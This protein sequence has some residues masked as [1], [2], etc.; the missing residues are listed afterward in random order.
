MALLD[1]VDT[2]RSVDPSNMYN[3]IFDFPEQMADALKLADG[4][5][6][7]ANDFAGIRNVVVIGMGGS[8]IGGDLVRTLLADRLV[9]P[10]FVN[11]H[12]KLPEFVDDETLVIASSYSGNTEE[13]LEALDDAL[14]RKAQIVAITTGGML[15]EVAKINEIPLMTIPGGM[16]PR[17]AL[18]FSFVPVLMLFEKLGMVKGLSKEIA[19]AIRLMQTFRE[20]YIEDSPTETN[21]AKNIAEHLLAKM[22]I[23]YTGPTLMDVVGIRWKGQ[24]CENGKNMTFH[25]V[26]PEFNHNEL[27]AWS[28]PIGPHTENLQ[29][30]LI[31]DQGD[32]PKVQ[33]R[34]DIVKGLIEKQ[35]VDVLEIRSIGDTP[36][37][38]MFSM[39]QLGDF[40]SYYLAVVNDTDPTPVEAIESLKKALSK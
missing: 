21:M 37:E 30:L 27:V 35:G 10:F 38:R 13:T 31:R 6:I 8:A 12:Y 19:G 5:N 24:F 1:D 2:I 20:R 36:L 15:E 39:I 17:A 18:G 34:M 9:I 29:V 22:A 7:R 40:A 3:R 33:K 4:W 28:D 11:R 14:N 23:V 32:H 26:F 16:Q 25:N